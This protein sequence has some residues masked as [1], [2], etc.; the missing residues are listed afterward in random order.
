MEGKEKKAT[1]TEKDKISEVLTDEEDSSEEGVLSLLK[2]STNFENKSNKRIQAIEGRFVG[3][4]NKNEN[5]IVDKLTVEVRNLK[6][7]SRNADNQIDYDRSC[8]CCQSIK[9]KEKESSF[10]IYQGEKEI[11]T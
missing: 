5:D 4:E 9:E 8:I 11:C 7:I 3:E 6:D 1:N 10:E 2:Q